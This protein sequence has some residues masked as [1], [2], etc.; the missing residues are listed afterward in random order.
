MDLLILS[1]DYS[2]LV[3]VCGVACGSYTTPT[4]ISSNSESIVINSHTSTYFAVYTQWA[5]TS[6]LTIDDNIV[7]TA[8]NNDGNGSQ[9]AS[10]QIFLNCKK[11]D[12]ITLN[13]NSVY[14]ASFNGQV[15][16]IGI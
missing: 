4:F 13:M 3:C 8:S 12:E 7:F 9:R 6:K 5:F 15:S 16:I 14:G 2:V 10:L 11:G 1:K